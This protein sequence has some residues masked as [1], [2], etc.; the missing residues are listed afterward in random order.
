[1]ARLFSNKK[2]ERK[3]WK[4]K[5]TFFSFAE[6]AFIKTQ[7]WGIYFFPPFMH[8]VFERRAGEEENSL[9]SFFSRLFRH[10]KKSSEPAWKKVNEPHQN[11]HL[12]ICLG[13]LALMMMP[14]GWQQARFFLRIFL[15]KKEE[16]N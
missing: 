7:K 4:T 3:P 5:I 8:V 13:L 11:D 14:A 2:K 16:R 6:A 9:L 15:Q 10:F 12:K 1:L